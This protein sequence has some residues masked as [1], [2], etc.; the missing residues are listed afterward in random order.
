MQ[1]IMR[2]V[3]VIVPVPMAVFVRMRSVL[4]RVHI[5]QVR[6]IVLAVVHLAEGMPVPVLMRMRMRVV[7]AMPVQMRWCL[8]SRVRFALD[9]RL[10]LSAST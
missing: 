10:A 4:C 5:V 9:A 2:P 6:G 3:P 7:M 8:C 1:I